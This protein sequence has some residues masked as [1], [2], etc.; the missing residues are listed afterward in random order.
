MISVA[1]A[2][3]LMLRG[4]GALTSER[5]RIEGA[6]GRVLADGL[7]AERDQPP[8][9][10][11]AMDGYAFASA[12]APRDFRIVGESA[13]G[14]A[15]LGALASGEAVSIS[16]GA[17]L[18]LGANGVLIQEEADVDAGYLRGAHVAAGA[19]VRARGI[20]FKRG[21]LVL[22]RGRMLDPIGLALAASTGASTLDV[23]ARPRVTILAGGN[24][25][26]PPG[27]QARDDQVFESAS[28]AL[29]G[30]VHAWGGVAQ[31]GPL[32]PDHDNAISAAAEAAFVECDLLVLI[33]GASVGP[34]DHARAA[35]QRLG[36]ELAVSKVAVKPGKPTWFG[37]SPR[38]PVLGLPG[39]PASAI[40]TAHLFL[41]PL[42]DAMLGRD[43]TLHLSRAPLAH[44]LPANGPRESYLR[45]RFDG[46]CLH[47]LEDQDSSLLSVFARANALL[48]RPIN[49]PGT[50]AGEA[51]AYF[52]I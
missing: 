51:A 24:E 52:A 4:V 23:V 49:A 28:F 3:A 38:G 36:V 19:F 7:Y 33:G 47:A 9:A 42:I 39:N 22:E 15:F 35:L 37:V 43:A 34:H 26:V 29:A 40:V 31:R 12:S 6:Y 27:A 5:V 10:A 41:R 25:I 21:A 2:R 11:S 48:L 14:A 44:A 30:L 45:A 16:T 32:L 18:P 50:A 13:A 1:E 17:P 8:F 46:E 20:D